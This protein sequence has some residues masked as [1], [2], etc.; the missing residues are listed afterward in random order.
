MPRRSRFLWRVA[1][2]VI[3]GAGRAVLSLEVER[4]APLPPPPFVIAANHYS[5][6]DP[7][8]IGA[9]MDM[10]VRFLALEELFGA[11]RVLEW[12]ILGFG[13]IP[14]P[15]HQLPIRA[16]RVALA[17]LGAGEVVGVFPEATRVSHWG[18]LPPKRGAAWLAK[19]ADV[20]LVPVAVIGTGRAFGLDNRWR[21]AQSRVVIGR[22]IQP[23]LGDT[24]TLTKQWERW[25]TQQ[26][27]RFPQSEVPGP[28]RSA[29][30]S[31]GF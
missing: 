29:R 25:M 5:H 24:K 2:P 26:I 17:R 19:R 11:N 28:R 1:P 13:A 4:E 10:P 23:S 9:V 12:L 8:V 14:T 15:R 7:P 3:R 6:L 16:V 22:A 31:E 27:E 18:T 30:W 21:R 20:P